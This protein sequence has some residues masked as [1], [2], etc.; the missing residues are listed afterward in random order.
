MELAWGRTR[1]WSLPVPRRLRTGEGLCQG[2]VSET[3]RDW[4]F[5]GIGQ[6]W[7][8]ACPIPGPT[9][10]SGY[11]ERLRAG[12]SGPRSTAQASQGRLPQPPLSPCTGS[13]G[14]KAVSSHS[15]QIPARIGRGC[16]HA[17]ALGF[18]ALDKS[19]LLFGL[20]FVI[21]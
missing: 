21:C 20:S 9:A 2:K 13:S 11:W 6:A 1:S 8:P 17:L 16:V 3:T 7:L 18:T 5:L 14:P 4:P 15:D 10:V 19:C 12:P